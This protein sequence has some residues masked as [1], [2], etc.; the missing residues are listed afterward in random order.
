[1]GRDDNVDAAQKFV[2]LLYK[3]EGNGAKGIDNARHSY[4]KSGN[5]REN[6]IFANGVKRHICDV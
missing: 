1:M 6:L 4:C 5:F 2:C 3:I